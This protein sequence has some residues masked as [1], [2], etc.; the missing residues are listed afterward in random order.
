MKIEFDQAKSDKNLRERASY[1]S[2]VQLI[3]TG[4]QQ[5]SLPIFAMTTQ[6]HAILPLGISAIVYMYFVSPQRMTQSEL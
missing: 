6:K 1:L 4:V 3:L 5:L 2:S